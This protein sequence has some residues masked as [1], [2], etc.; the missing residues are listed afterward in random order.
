MALFAPILYCTRLICKYICMYIFF[1]MPMLPMKHNLFVTQTRKSVCGVAF[2]FKL[3]KNS[4]VGLESQIMFTVCRC[5]NVTCVSFMWLKFFC[6]VGTRASWTSCFFFLKRSEA[7]AT[8]RHKLKVRF[9]FL[10]K[11]QWHSGCLNKNTRLY[12]SDME[13]LGIVLDMLHEGEPKHTLLF[14]NVCPSNT[15]LCETSLFTALCHDNWIW[16]S[17][18]KQK[19]NVG[20][21]VCGL[22][23]R[24]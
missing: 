13:I 17:V 19:N 24:N 8:K 21:S 10:N 22:L 18:S 16:N 1:I 23:E 5:L 11:L 6:I 9:H 12:H 4:R 20:F 3:G 7:M 2:Y 15:K 14:E